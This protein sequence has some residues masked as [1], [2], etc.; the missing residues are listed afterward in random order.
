MSV[1][2]LLSAMHLQNE[3][4]I[5][6][7]NIH[8]DC[9]V[10]SQCDS[11]CVRE[12]VHN[13]LTGTVNVKYIETDERGLS[14]SR[15]MA[16]KNATGDICILCDNDVEYVQDYD[17]IID[18]AFAQNPDADLIGFFIERPE[19]HSPV[20]TR[21]KRMGYLS[22]L[23]IFS[24]EIAF[25]RKS[26]EGL[27]FN[28]YFGAGAKYFM[29]EENLFLYECLKRGLKIVYVPKKIAKVRD[30]ESTWFKGYT[31][32]FFIS[33]GANYTAMSKTFSLLL[34][35]QFAVRK[36]GLY[37]SDMSTCK[38]IKYM[39]E[40]RREYLSDIY[41]NKTEETGS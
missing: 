22:V 3:D 9:V 11:C 14:K 39:F 27:K 10:I 37:H 35:L 34:I 6:T 23:K 5:D 20:F 32:D 31:A 33:R 21:T 26:I 15:N 4:Y 28:E 12:T 18:G 29:G 13:A 1:E 40:G 17:S 16:I 24:P 38:A 2:V 25:R 19:R 30:N 7:L 8:T 41:R 36:R